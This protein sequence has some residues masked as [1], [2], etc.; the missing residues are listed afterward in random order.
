MEIESMVE[1]FINE[2]KA[3]YHKQK[4]QRPRNS[5]KNEKV[6]VDSI[7]DVGCGVKHNLKNLLSQLSTTF[8]YSRVFA[9]FSKLNG[10]FKLSLI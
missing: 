1:G 3:I 9:K 7:L 5:F 10:Q 6:S 4:A 2:L 8:V